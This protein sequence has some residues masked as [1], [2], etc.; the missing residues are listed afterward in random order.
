M[1][2]VKD[3]DPI[4]AL[5]DPKSVISE[6][7]GALRSSLLYS[8]RD[9]LPQVVLV[10]SAQASEGKST[11]SFAVARSMAQVGK[12]TLLVDGAFGVHQ[13]NA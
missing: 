4:V 12:R 7:Y 1:P 13:F 9:G 11:T 3:V 2:D 8:T 10:T 6:S 5:T